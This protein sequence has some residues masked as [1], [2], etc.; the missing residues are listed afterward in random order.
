MRARIERL[1][2]RHELRSDARRRVHRHVITNEVRL[3]QR[4]LVQM[5][6]GDILASDLCAS[7]LQPR[8]GRGKAKRL[9]AQFVSGNQDDVH[10]PQNVNRETKNGEHSQSRRA[11]MGRD[12]AQCTACVKRRDI[13]VTFYALRFTHYVS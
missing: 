11:S 4:L 10:N 7:A 2:V 9:M 8:R 13:N 6:H 5:L 1:D 3:S 12:A